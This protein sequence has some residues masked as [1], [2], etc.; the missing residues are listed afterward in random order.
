MNITIIEWDGPFTLENLK[1]LDKPHDYGVYQVYGPNP[2]HGRVDLL[3]IGLASKQT[4]SVRIPIH[5]DWINGTRDSSQASIHV[6]R[7]LG[8]ETPEVTLWEKQIVRAEGLLIYAHYP[9][10]NRQ[11][12][13]IES[14]PE[15][16]HLRVFN[17]GRYRDLLPEI[18]GARLG[19]MPDMKPY[20]THP[21]VTNP[22]PNIAFPGQSS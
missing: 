3:Y 21:P 11:K 15:L 5:T 12:D 19:K 8:I 20:G 10:Y 16:R 9:L 6:G 18:S 22:V 2:T 14:D 17:I 1:A 7:L 13:S 4:F